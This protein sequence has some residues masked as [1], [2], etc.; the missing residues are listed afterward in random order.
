MMLNQPVDSKL[1]KDTKRN[2]NGFIFCKHHIHY[3]LMTIYHED[4]LSRRLFCFGSFVILVVARC[5]LWLFSLY[6]NIKIGKNS[7]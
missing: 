5:Y 4:N 2:K 1:Q 3:D 7:C 6:I